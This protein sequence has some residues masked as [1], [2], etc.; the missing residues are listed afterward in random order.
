M[1]NDPDILVFFFGVLVG[2]VFG[3]LIGAGA[4]QLIQEIR[5]HMGRRG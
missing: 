2:V 5:K 4:Y 3:A 1:N